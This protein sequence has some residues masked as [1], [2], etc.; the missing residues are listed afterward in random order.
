VLVVREPRVLLVLDD[1]DERQASD[2]AR[3]GAGDE[4]GDDERPG[5]HYPRRGAL[6]PFRFLPPTA[7]CAGEAGARAVPISERVGVATVFTGGPGWA[8]VV[9]PGRRPP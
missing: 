7:D 3:E 9:R 4:H 6:P 2:E 8:R 1:L 5:P